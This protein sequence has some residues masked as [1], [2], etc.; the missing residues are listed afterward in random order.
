MATTPAPDARPDYNSLGKAGGIV[1]II[2]LILSFVPFIGFVSWLLGPLAILFGLVALR[3]TPRSWAIVGLITGAITLIVCFSWLSATKS[4]GDAMSADT[5]NTSGVARDN[6]NAPEVAA[7]IKELWSEIEANKVAAGQKYGGK[8]LAFSNEK[9]ANFTGDANN[10]GLQFV[11]NKDAY[12]EY[13]VSASFDKADG[14]K[15]SEMSKGQAVSFVC[16]NI[17]ETFSEGYSLSDC[18]LK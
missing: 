10:P 12:M 16:T 2:G 15:I 14:S 13:Y 4:V 11:G 9:V 5:F 8:Q 1:G 7:A 3:K 17:S 18:T 6:T